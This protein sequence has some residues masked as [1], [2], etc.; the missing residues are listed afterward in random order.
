MRPDD[1]LTARKKLF[2]S[3]LSHITKAGGWLTSVPG[4]PLIRFEAM[5]GSRLPDD[6]RERGFTPD[7][8]RLLAPVV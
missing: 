6:L 2:A 8:C 7:G 4:D 5:P 1:A 3:L